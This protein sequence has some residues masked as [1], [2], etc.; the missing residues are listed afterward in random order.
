M[1]IINWIPSWIFP[2]IIFAGIIGYIASFILTFIPVVNLYSTVIRIVSIIITSIGIW[3][4]AYYSGEKA[5]EAKWQE[6][7][8]Q[9]EEKIIQAE[10]ESKELNEKLRIKQSEYD[11]LRTEKNKTIIK[12]LDKWNT[13]EI[14]VEI[15]G[16]ERI[17]IEKVI[18]YI[19]KCPIPKELLDAHNA[20][21]KNQGM[22]K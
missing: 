22:T 11:Q 9:A 7:I 8:K 4:T 18:E 12:Y 15:Q 3:F 20:A 21:A 6:N 17:K 10:K 14:P 2:L 13:K 5:N 1:S 16:P 19:E